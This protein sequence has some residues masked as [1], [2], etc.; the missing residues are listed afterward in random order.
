M[1][2]LGVLLAVFSLAA[3]APGV[4]QG[5]GAPT[6]H[7]I[8]VTG[9]GGQP[10]YSDLFHTQGKSLMGAAEDRWGVP[11]DNIVWLAEAPDRDPDL[12][13]DR[14]T[15][16]ALEAAILS[17]A[18]RAGPSDGVMIVLIG[19]GSG[20]GDESKINLPGPDLSGGDLAEALGAF[21]SQTVAIVNTASASGGFVQALSGE[22]RIVVTA[23]RS[24]REKERT[25]FGSYFVDAYLDEGADVDKDERVSLLE[26]FQFASGEV[27][28]RY[29]RDNQMLTEHALL[30]D[31]GDREGSA[32]PGATQSD[33]ALAGRFFLVSTS[34]SVAQQAV[35]D[36]ELAALLEDKTRIET[37]I[38]RLRQLR[39]T[40]DPAAYD[41]E[42]ERLVL[43]LASV[44]RQIRDKGDRA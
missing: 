24:P 18:S 37:A 5:S 43:E 22:R 27:A 44:N 26:A 25:Y 29:E 8:V 11:R 6:T 42:L 3:P 12:V 32:A 17:A 31:N 23:T 15:K 16:E 39:D 10:E 1:K 7:L 21:S 4:S 30:D 2:R 40:M 9:L 38:A 35:D 28:R 33:G 13:S 34:K 20:E 41:A 36:P 19:H 14:S